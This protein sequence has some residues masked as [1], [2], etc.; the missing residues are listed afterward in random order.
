MTTLAAYF[1]IAIIVCGMILIVNPAVVLQ[2][3]LDQSGSRGFMITAFLARLILAIVLALVAAESR[4]PV[5]I[6]F[7]ALLAFLGAVFIPILG[8]KK[9]SEIISKS[10]RMNATVARLGGV[11]TILFGW[12]LIYAVL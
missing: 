10:A 8:S 4:Y 7:I 2:Y 3:I 9:F 12:F 6:G 11:G 5:F 1:A